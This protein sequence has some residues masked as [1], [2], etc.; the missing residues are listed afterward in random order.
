MS[1][2]LRSTNYELHVKYKAGMG[3]DTPNFP[4]AMLLAGKHSTPDQVVSVQ[5]LAGDIVLCSWARH[6]ILRVPLLHPGV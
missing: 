6:L 5:A 3:G 4:S 2:K 1:D